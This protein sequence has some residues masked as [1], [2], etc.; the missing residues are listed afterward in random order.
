M[1]TPQ[2]TTE[3]VASA[4]TAF[5]SEEPSLWRDYEGRENARDRG[6]LARS[7]RTVSLSPEGPLLQSGA[8]LVYALDLEVGVLFVVVDA[9]TAQRLVGASGR[10]TCRR[11]GR[12]ATDSYS[13]NAARP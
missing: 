11:W 12:A 5:V 7:N 8:E 13:C 9:L 2:I 3:A 10:A 6:V 4:G 1:S